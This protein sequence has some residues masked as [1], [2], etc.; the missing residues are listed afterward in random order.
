MRDHSTHF[1][2][3]V[4]V[5]C[6]VTKIKHRRLVILINNYNITLQIKQLKF[7]TTVHSLIKHKV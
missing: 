5:E 7:S 4:N 3:K 1:I 2:P 6:L